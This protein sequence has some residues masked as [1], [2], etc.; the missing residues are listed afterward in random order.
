MTELVQSHRDR[1]QDEERRL[2]DEH[3]VFLGEI[4]V[5]GLSEV[6]GELIDH[7]HARMT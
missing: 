1:H 4:E 5:E 2:I 7:S 3:S 6:A